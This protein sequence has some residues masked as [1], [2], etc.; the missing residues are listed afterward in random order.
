MSRDT[1]RMH[2]GYPFLVTIEEPTAGMTS[3]SALIKEGKARGVK[4][5]IVSTKIPK[6]Q[7]HTISTILPSL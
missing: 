7:C 2:Y 1:L 5:S 4:V 3:L 6:M